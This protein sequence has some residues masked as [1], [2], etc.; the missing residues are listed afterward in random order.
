MSSLRNQIRHAS[1][2]DAYIDAAK[3]AAHKGE[4][5]NL[6]IPKQFGEMV[7]SLFPH[8]DSSTAKNFLA[9]YLLAH[10]PSQGSKLIEP[11]YTAVNHGM[12]DMKMYKGFRRNYWP[13]FF[14]G[15]E[16]NLKSDRRMR[17]IVEKHA[18]GEFLPRLVWEDKE[19]PDS[20]DDATKIICAL[21]KVPNMLA[22]LQPQIVR[23]LVK[24][25]IVRQE[26]GVTAAPKLGKLRASNAFAEAIAT[27]ENGQGIHTCAYDIEVPGTRSS[28]YGPKYVSIALEFALVGTVNAYE[29][30]YK[31]NG[32]KA[33]HIL[34]VDGDCLK[35]GTM[36]AE[37]LM[38]RAETDMPGLGWV[39]PIA[40]RMAFELI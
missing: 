24:R 18:V 12:T 34:N 21:D 37:A 29:L 8:I 1:S 22:N 3:Q 14:A 15:L 4:D 25:H 13:E 31:Q 20:L 40:E 38:K 10:H 16:A 23:D 36:V 17:T 27:H 9:F 2:P 35:H 5:P 19:T 28:V 32:Y 39:N 30:T 7:L 11:F 6:I 33:Q 26:G